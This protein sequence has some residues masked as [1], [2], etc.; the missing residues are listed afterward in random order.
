MKWRVH[1][2]SF[3]IFLFAFGAL[4]LVWDNPKIILYLILLAIGLVAYAAIY[5]VV[6]AKVDN[7]DKGLI[8]DK[9]HDGQSS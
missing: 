7:P 3:L 6:K 1:V 8:H 4:K 2:I 5:V 9:R